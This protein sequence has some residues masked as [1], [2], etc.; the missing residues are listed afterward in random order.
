MNPKKMKPYEMAEK[1]RI[2]KQNTMMW[3]QGQ[4]IYEAFAVVMSN[5]FSKGKTAEYSK[6][7]YQIF[8]LTKEEQEEKDRKEL[9]ALI[10]RLNGIKTNWDANHEGK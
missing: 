10:A 1:L 5:A 7:P 4:Y 9:E 2:K 3:I 8:P 6:E